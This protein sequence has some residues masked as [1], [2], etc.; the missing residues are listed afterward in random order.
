MKKIAKE[1]FE[2]N[3]DNFILENAGNPKTYW[4]IMKMLLTSGKATN[5]IPQLQNIINDSN[6]SEMAYSD[7]EKCTL[8]NKYFCSISKLDDENHQLPD[9]VSRTNNHIFYI[10]IEKQEIIDIIQIYNRI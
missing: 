10:R 3:L 6:L 1:Q 5:N 7:E 8:L 9:F 4:K 2:S